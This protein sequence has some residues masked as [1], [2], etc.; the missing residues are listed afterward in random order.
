MSGACV[1]SARSRK[2][3]KTI[4]VVEKIE[5]LG[6]RVSG[7]RFPIKGLFYTSYNMVLS[8]QNPMWKV[9]YFLLFSHE[10][11]HC[12]KKKKIR[13]SFVQCCLMINYKFY[14]KNI[15]YPCAMPCVL[16]NVCLPIN[17]LAN[18]VPLLWSSV[19]QVR[20]LDWP[21]SWLGMPH[22]CI[23]TLMKK[24]SWCFGV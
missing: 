13:H 17:S 15:Q 18:H 7:E 20:F 4:F 10:K 16:R 11:I 14:R 1:L 5:F 21:Y 24:H 19:Y 6:R 3:I 8:V 2:T 22:C 9:N 12:Y 23:P